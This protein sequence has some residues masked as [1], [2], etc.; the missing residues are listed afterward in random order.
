MEQFEIPEQ[1]ETSRGTWMA[2]RVTLPT[3]RQIALD[4][5]SRPDGCA[6]P[7]CQKE[8]RV[9]VLIGGRSRHRMYRLCYSHFAE[10]RRFIHELERYYIGASPYSKEYTEKNGPD[11]PDRG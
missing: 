8:S 4:L 11:D 1:E 6:W 7:D 9:T 2:W 5:I 10:V 3:G